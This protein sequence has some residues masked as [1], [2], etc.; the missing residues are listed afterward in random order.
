MSFA[1]IT[2]EMLRSDA[3]CAIARTLM[4]RQPRVPKN[5]P[6][7]PGMPCHVVADDGEDAAALR[8]LDPLHLALRASS[9]ANARSTTSRTCS[10]DCSRTAKQIECS[11]L[12]CEISMTEMPASRRAPNSRSAVPG[13]AD[14]A[15]ALEIDQRDAVDTA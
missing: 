11:E 8:D 14:H 1:S 4:P 5:R 15:G 12:P 3:P 2:A 10:A 13:H 6:A 9:A 7:L